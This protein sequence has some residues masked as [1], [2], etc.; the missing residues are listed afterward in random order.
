M[1]QEGSE[2]LA[3]L[4]PLSPPGNQVWHGRW[5]PSA[6]LC[7]GLLFVSCLACKDCKPTDTLPKIYTK[8]VSRIIAPLH[9]SKTSLRLIS[10]FCR[11][12]IRANFVYICASFARS[13]VLG[14]HANH[15]SWLPFCQFPSPFMPWSV[16]S[17]IP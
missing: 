6:D 12:G 3:G 7:L 17:R 9:Q 15:E 13:K 2:L 1:Y 11:C 10:L 4:C 14:T 16:L 8:P 5:E